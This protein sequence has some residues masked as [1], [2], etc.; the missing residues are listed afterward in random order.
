M[1]LRRKD[2]PAADGLFFG[3]TFY[4]GE[5]LKRSEH[6]FN[7]QELRPYFPYEQTEKGL[8]DAAARL[9]HVSISK[10]KNEDVWDS[11]VSTWDVSDRGKLIGRFFLDMHPRPGKDKRFSQEDLR[12]GIAGEQIPEGALICNFPASQPGA[13]ALLDHSDVIKMFHE[14][15]HLMHQMVATQDWAGLSGAGG[16]ADFNEAPSQMIEQWVEDPGVL[17][18]FAKHYQS[19]QPI[20]ESLLDSFARGDRVGRAFRERLQIWLSEFSLKLHSAQAGTVDPEQLWK[21]TY[22]SFFTRPLI[23]RSTVMFPLRTARRAPKAS[24]SSKK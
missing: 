1:A 11:S 18:Q 14:L 22:H 8:L 3:D 23:L 16:E 19:G 15:G 21:E 24:N 12:P 7:A 13:P 2:D 17:R 4:Y 10:V 5:Q 20:P 9:F 6:S